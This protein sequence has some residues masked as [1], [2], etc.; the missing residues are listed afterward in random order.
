MDVELDRSGE[1]GEALDRE[2]DDS[3]GEIFRGL[4]SRPSPNAARFTAEIWGLAAADGLALVA[5]LC[6]YDRN[7]SGVENG[8][9]T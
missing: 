5:R 8:A 4:G 1:G 6:A 7:T 9:Y 3:A 2:K